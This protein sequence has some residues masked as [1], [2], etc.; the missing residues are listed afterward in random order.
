[1]EITMTLSGKWD[2]NQAG[3][4]SRALRRAGWNPCPSDSPRK[5]EAGLRVARGIL[6]QGAN[7]YLQSASRREMTTWAADMS[8]TLESLGYGFE[9]GEVADLPMGYTL[10]FRNVKKI[11]K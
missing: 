10:A 2:S 5:H 3:A 6:G 4:L 11:A 9:C 1:M 8:Q 7:V